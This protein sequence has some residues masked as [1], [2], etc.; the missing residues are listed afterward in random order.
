MQNNDGYDGYY[1]SE[2]HSSIEAQQ[3]Q[4]YQEYQ[5]YLFKLL[6]QGKTALFAA[7]VALDWLHSREFS[8]SGLSAVEFIKSKKIK[9][10]DG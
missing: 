1:E 2:W 5:D 6:E 4:E 8:E 9:F 10:Q 3:A 7:Y